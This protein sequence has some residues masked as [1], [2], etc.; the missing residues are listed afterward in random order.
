MDWSLQVI[1]YEEMY[2]S[3]RKFYDSSKGA[4]IL[5]QQEWEKSEKK[6]ENQDVL[7]SA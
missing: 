1:F 5:K 4:E 2:E 3:K 6:K 7:Q